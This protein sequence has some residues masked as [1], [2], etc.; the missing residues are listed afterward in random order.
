M[1]H[2]FWGGGC[3][4]RPL[5]VGEGKRAS[6]LK[7]FAGDETAAPQVLLQKTTPNSSLLWSCGICLDCCQNHG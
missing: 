4:R 2:L 3:H 5:A 7:I 1:A 6:L